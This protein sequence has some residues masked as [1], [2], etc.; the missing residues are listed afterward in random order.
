[1]DASAVASADEAKKTTAAAAATAAGE[2][3]K[4]A[5]V[6]PLLAQGYV[7][8][9]LAFERV[10]WPVFSDDDLKH[11]SPEQR[12]EIDKMAALHKALDD[13]LA[14][15]QA[16]VSRQVE[17]NGCYVVGESY[18]A[19]QAKLEALIKEEWAKI[20]WSAFEF[21]G[22]G[23]E[24][25]QPSAKK[26][27]QLLQAEID[28]ILAWRREPSPY[29][30]DDHWAL[31]SPEQLQL[32]EEMAAIGKE[33][34]DSF[35][36][37]Q[38]EVRREVEEKG[39]Y[40]VDEIYYA[41][42]A[43]MQAQ[44]KE[45]WAKIDW[46]DV[47]CADW[48]DFN[49]PN[50]SF[51]ENMDS[52]AAAAAASDEAAEN[53]PAAAAAAAT[54]AA[55]AAEAVTGVDCADDAA[56]A[57]TTVDGDGGDEN[58]KQQQPSV[59]KLHMPQEYVDY[60]LAWKKRPF[61]LPDDGEILSPE[62]RE[63]RERMAATCNELGDGFEEFQAEVRRVVEE[64]GFYEVDESY[65]ANQAEIQAQLKEGWAKIDWG[66]IV[67]ADWDDFDD[68]NC[69]RSLSQSSNLKRATA[70]RRGEEPWRSRRRGRYRVGVA[71]D[72]SVSY[73]PISIP[74]RVRVLLGF[75]S[76]YKFNAATAASSSFFYS[77][78]HNPQPSVYELVDISRLQ[79][80]RIERIKRKMEAEEGTTTTT[81]VKK[82]A[83]EAVEVTGAAAEEIFTEQ[84]DELQA[85]VSEE[86][87]KI[88][89]KSIKFGDWDYDDP[90]CCHMPSIDES[91]IT[92]QED[93]LQALV[94][95]EFA[96]ID[97]SGIVFGDWDY[98]DPTCLTKGPPGRTPVLKFNLPFGRGGDM[99]LKV[100]LC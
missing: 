93:E 44:L 85:L 30:D 97:L 67:F 25:K 60:I 9:I 48:D 89:L 47:V 13:D 23:G 83:A 55:A 98:D 100:K 29:P 96:K 7:D 36:E 91:C 3:Q 12:R 52:A 5:A 63:M 61:P 6:A 72:R 14:V 92:K 21:D 42:Q 79:A 10:Q 19:D 40:E 57:A 34:E 75:A 95:E 17:D 20:D 65:F 22:S 31:L 38:A 88:D 50:C 80:R 86:F 28:F 27:M 1:M 18:L 11:L 46:S 58:S 76:P 81:T 64:K 62:H 49:D 54:V 84:D 2:P 73:T 43:E 39:F 15:F 74:D 33:F 66:D 45:G 94:T 77:H 59:N 32:R 69:C 56:A 99:E 4:P 53:T 87:A 70:R 78:N 71:T 16:E 37:F 24:Q 35:E 51:H 82:P 41:D 68:P 8:S 26:M 90:I